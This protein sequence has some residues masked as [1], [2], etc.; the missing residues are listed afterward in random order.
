MGGRSAPLTLGFWG[1]V[2]NPARVRGWRKRAAPF[3]GKNPTPEP[4]QAGCHRR[5][6]GL[7]CLIDAPGQ[8][9]QSQTQCTACAPFVVEAQ[10]L[11]PQTS[12][13]LS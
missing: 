10:A 2:I 1:P 6:T 12:C 5:V 9:D 3:K 13:G 11:P 7:G 8:S 4:V